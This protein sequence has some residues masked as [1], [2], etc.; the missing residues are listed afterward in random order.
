MITAK[1]N[2]GRT[3]TKLSISRIK[4]INAIAV[5]KAQSTLKYVRWCLTQI[6]QGERIVAALS[7]YKR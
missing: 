7:L 1:I 3:K 4:P 6:N 5:E 2:K